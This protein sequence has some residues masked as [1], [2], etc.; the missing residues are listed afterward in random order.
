MRMQ[1]GLFCILF[2]IFLPNV[3]LQF[4]DVYASIILYY[5]APTV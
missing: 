4:Q 2:I 3:G 5:L 1:R